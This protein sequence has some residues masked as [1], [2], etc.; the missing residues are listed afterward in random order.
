MKN[1]DALTRIAEQLEALNDNVE[2][3]NEHLADQ[4]GTLSETNEKLDKYGNEIALT[5]HENMYSIKEDIS[6][7]TGIKTKEYN[8]EHE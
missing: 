2:T 5:L 3:L 4:A 6:S 1:K 8:E 7:L